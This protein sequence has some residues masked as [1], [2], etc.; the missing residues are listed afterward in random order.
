MGL[1]ADRARV[2][3]AERR[4]FARAAGSD[5]GEREAGSRSG[6]ERAHRA[7]HELRGLPHAHDAAPAREIGGRMAL[8]A[9]RLLDKFEDMERAVERDLR[10]AQR[11]LKQSIPSYLRESRPLNLLAAP[12]VY[13]MILPI[14]LLDGW[15][16]AYQWICFPLF[17]IATVKRRSYVVIDRHKLSYL[18]AI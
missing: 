10:R 18:N 4:V 8:Q 13:S 6:R 1:C 15:I 3:S 14:A 7:H 17:G 9:E 12:I 2:S 11:R 16:T 5:R